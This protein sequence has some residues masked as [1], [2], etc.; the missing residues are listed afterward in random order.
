MYAVVAIG[1]RMRRSAC[2]MNFR[3]FCC[4][5]AQLA[6]SARPSAAARSETET[7]FILISLS[8]SH[9]TSPALPL[10]LWERAGVRGMYLG[11]FSFSGQHAPRSRACRTTTLPRHRTIHHHAVDTFRE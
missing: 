4:A 3:T 1:S 5:D 9:A 11:G 7:T 8:I 10:P 2:G 6:A